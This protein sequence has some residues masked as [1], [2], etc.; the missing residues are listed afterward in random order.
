MT[1]I[2]LELSVNTSDPDFVLDDYLDC[3]MD[4][5]EKINREAD[6]TA[7]VAR[8]CA[9]F[10]LD[11]SDRSDEEFIRALTDMRTALHAA[12]CSTPNWPTSHEFLA[13]R[14]VSQD[15]LV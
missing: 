6:Y 8:M 15:V 12:G 1:Q 3:V 13:V 5:L 10:T 2:E 4:Q 9:T 14:A 7:I 11:A